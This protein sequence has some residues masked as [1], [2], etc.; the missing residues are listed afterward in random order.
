MTQNPFERFWSLGYEALLPIIPPDAEISERSSLHK[1]VG[2]PQDGRG[3]T[4]GT[5]G[6]DGKW[7]SFDWSPYHADLDDLARWQGMGAGVGIK[8]GGELIAID[9]DTLNLTYARIIQE[10]V[11]ATLGRLPVRVGNYPKALYLCRVTEPM[12]Y[13]RI[14]FGTERVEILSDGR[15]F[16]AEGTHPKTGKPYAWPRPLV[17]FDDLPTFTPDQIRALLADL[18]AKLPIPS[19]TVTEGGG[20]EVDQKLLIGDPAAVKKAVEAIPNTADQFPTREAYLSFGYAIKAAM[21]DDPAGAFAL[22][23]DWCA[24]WTDGHNDPDIVAAD[25]RRMKP[26]FKR[27]ASFLFDMAEETGKFSRA[28]IWFEE[29]APSPFEEQAVLTGQTPATIHATPYGFPNPAEIERR[30]WVY[31]NHY[32]RKFVSATVAPS[33]VGKSSLEIV[34]ALAIAS[35]KPLLGVEPRGR[36]RVWLW[37]GEDPRDELSRRIAAA[38][39]HYQL[40]PA[41]IGDRLFVDTGRETEIIL[42]TE[43]RDGAKIM[44]PVVSALIQTVRENKIDVIQI[45]PF[46]SSHRVSENDNGAI[47]LVTKQWAKIADATGCAVELVHHVRKLNGAEITVE[48]SRGAVALIATSRSARALTR[49]SKAEGARLGLEGVYRR[50]FR[51]GDGKN[52]LALPA[53][54]KTEWMQLCS[55]VLGNGLPPGADGVVD[56]G[57]SVGVVSRYV[58]PDLV[59]DTGGTGVEMALGLIA[60]GVWRRDIRA[61]DAWAGCAIGQALGLDAGDETDRTQLKSLLSGWIKAGLLREVTRPDASRRPRTYVEVAEKADKVSES[62]LD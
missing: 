15:Q 10:T 20:A 30:Q 37:N 53:D 5:R 56:L 45:D 57:D 48:D 31:G 4:P 12:A 60:G 24:R 39:L 47:D 46:V 34:E 18:A 7:S 32:I 27:G 23:E 38:M 59:V 26:P 8:T 58:V 17:P 11:D 33:G 41:D 28:D 50:L 36:H 16:V 42:A 51:F 9:A 43:T 35:G 44:A 6:R 62:V 54:D 52:N 29:I 40:T 61:G 13:T 55:V 14:E 22:F 21:P 49:M 19:R 25:W 1:R 3:K 2:T